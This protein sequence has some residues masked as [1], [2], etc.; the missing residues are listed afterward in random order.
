MDDDDNNTDTGDASRNCNR[1]QSCT[2]LEDSVTW[3]LG[4]VL[5][6]GNGDDNDDDDDDDDDDD[7]GTNTGNASRNSN[8]CYCCA[9][10]KRR[11][12]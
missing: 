4:L 6:T 7:N 2:W 3:W 8:R 1:R 9:T 10:L 11:S 5:N 12:S